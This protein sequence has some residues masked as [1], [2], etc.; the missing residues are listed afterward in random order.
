MLDCTEHGGRWAVYEI[1]NNGDISNNIG[2]AETA[3]LAW[4]EAANFLNEKLNKLRKIID[5]GMWDE[6]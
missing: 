6:V 2:E 3:E 4:M 5:E 1:M